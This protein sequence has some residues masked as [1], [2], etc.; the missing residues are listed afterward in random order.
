MIFYSF[1]NPRFIL[2]W[3]CANP[4][5]FRSDLNWTNRFYVRIGS[6]FVQFCSVLII[7]QICSQ[8]PTFV[9]FKDFLG[10]RDE[11]GKLLINWELCSKYKWSW[12]MTSLAL[13]VYFQSFHVPINLVKKTSL[14]ERG[15]LLNFDAIFVS[16]MTSLS[17]SV[18]LDSSVGC[19]SEEN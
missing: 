12:Y 6:D 10:Q 11:T 5:R 15:K 2:F 7:H 14:V 9:S 8:T 18:F 19:F 13:N 16:R 1:V 3:T 4:F 17:A